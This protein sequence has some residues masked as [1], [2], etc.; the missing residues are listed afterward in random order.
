M[1]F[2]LYL[3]AKLCKWEIEARLSDVKRGKQDKGF[4]QIGI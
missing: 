4:K 2:F 1:D 3:C